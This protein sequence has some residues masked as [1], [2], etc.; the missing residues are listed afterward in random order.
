MTDVTAKHLFWTQLI[1]S[2]LCSMLVIG[3]VN[4]SYRADLFS[5]VDNFLYDLHFKWRGPVPTSGKI[6]VVLMDEVS[7]VELSRQ[8]GNW[9]RQQL[10]EALNNLCAA[11]AEIIGLDMILSAPDPDPRVDLALAQA[12]NECNNVV[13]ARVSA[14]QGV[15]EI[16]PQEIFQQGMIGDGFIDL[17]LDED[18]VL[19][20]IRFLTAKPQ[21]DGSLQLLPA[22]SLE[23]VRTFLNLDFDF[24]FSSSNY[25]LMG[26]AGTRQLRLPYPE[27]RINYYGN[28]RSF[29]ELSYADVVNN[30]FKPEA[31]KGKI[32]LVGSSLASQKDFF[33]TPFSRFQKGTDDYQDRFGQ[34]E[35]RVQGEQDPGVSCHAQAVETILNQDFLQPVG[36]AFIWALVLAVGLAG[37]IFYLPRIG[38]LW[39]IICL[40]GGVFLLVFISH[41]LFVGQ[42][43]QV[44]LAP[45][46]VVLV[47]QFV[48][49]V[50]V[51]KSF[52]KRKTALV[53]SLF[54]KYVSP[55]VVGELIKGDIKATLE[56]GRQSLTMLFSDL[57][58]FT[59]LSEK[60]GA[61]DTGL[62]LNYYFDRM[63]PLVFAHQGTLDKLM[64]DAVMAFFGAPLPVADHPVKAAETAL[65]MIDQLA[66]IRNSGIKGAEDLRIGI[67]LNT[68]EVTVGNLGSTAFMDYTIIGDAVNLASRLEGINKVYGTAIIISEFTAAELDERFVLR[69]LD[70]VKVKGK[71]KA[72]K[73]FELVGWRTKI[74]VSQEELVILFEQGLAAYR[75][76]QWDEAAALFERVLKLKADDGPARLYLQRIS[77]FRLT[78]PSEEWQGITSFDHK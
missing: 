76:R 10:T 39:E 73:I 28:H 49:G 50:V 25:F 9:S 60:L 63:I 55:G 16:M 32:I 66:G 7:A 14:A 20:K 52:D 69:D 77:Q 68:G 38:M 35:S 5:R 74:S 46:L 2:C 75:Q 40:V 47:G 24:D 51:Q 42:R 37:V 64:G 22:F 6:T 78:P 11:G 59:N 34:I 44:D 19:R 48:F 58:G 27:L 4:L 26:A 62:L 30:R 67:G 33:S 65:E 61:R 17:P 56:G 29:L 45:L 70:I 72:V 12:V 57:R 36:Q 54:G 31:V 3:L 41:R 53:T 8:K 43:L 23:L 1:V 21:A 71:D 15:A 18:E 13:L